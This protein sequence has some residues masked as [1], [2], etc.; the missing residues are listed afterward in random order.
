MGRSAPLSFQAGEE[1]IRVWEENGAA[2]VFLPSYV[3]LK[4]VTVQTA[5]PLHL[6][7]LLLKNG[8]DCGGLELGRAYETADGGTLTVLKSENL[9]ALYLDTVS[10]NMDYIHKKKGNRESG[11]MRLY[12]ETGRLTAAGALKKIQARGNSTFVPEKKPYSLTLSRQADLLGMGAAKNWILLANEMDPSHLKNK[13]VY[14][15]AAEAGLPYSPESRWVDVYLN[16]NY[17]GLYLLC[18]RNE[19]AQNR[20]ELPKNQGF[21]VSKEQLFNLEQG[22]APYFETDA[23]AFL[24]VRKNT[25]GQTQ[26]ER[27]FQRA[28]NAI[29]APDGLD[30]ETGRH[31]QDLIDLD[32]WAGKYLVEEIFG[33]IDAGIAS[34]YFFYAPGEDRLYAGPVWDFD[35]TMGVDIWLGGELF[36]EQVP[37]MYFAHRARETPWYHSLY[38]QEAFFSRM[39]ELYR[40]NYSELL[41][42]YLQERLPAYEAQ[43]RQ[44]AQLNRIRWK[45][46][47]PGE[48]ADYLS[49][50]VSRRMA[51]LNAA[52]IE[53]RKFIPVHVDFSYEEFMCKY[54]VFDYAV[55]PGGFLPRL[56]VPE[57]YRWYFA[58]TDTPFDPGRPIL[59]ETSVEL[60][61][62]G[63]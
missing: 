20:V 35:E 13:F 43:I 12:D 28:E 10:G 1:T 42:V 32:S 3:D 6:D 63:G 27:I 60:H 48:M 22:D 2:Y 25:L 24:R 56:A 62:V 38:G 61:P 8:R 31:W 30:P 17:A 36:L 33:G 21:L 52:W 45:S 59:E 44:A 11:A 54:A 57:G 15:F 5:Q 47:D 4:N 50:Y 51:F 7:D 55:S 49:W 40:Q 58:G 19:I 29:L 34:Q 37:E 46:R 18:E 23:G 16:G 14:D 26:M 39:T 41:A 9:P 53:N